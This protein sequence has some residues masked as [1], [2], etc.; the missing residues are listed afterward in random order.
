[1]NRKRRL[2]QGEAEKEIIYFLDK[3]YPN[4][5]LSNEYNEI[6]NDVLWLDAEYQNHEG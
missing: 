2:V 4:L 1:L 3:T 5:V 6:I